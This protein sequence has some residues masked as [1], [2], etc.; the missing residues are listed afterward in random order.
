MV[1]ARKRRPQT[2][3]RMFEFSPASGALEVNPA[4]SWIVPDVDMRA[5]LLFAAGFRG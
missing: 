1:V 3:Q 5:E 4:A 2:T